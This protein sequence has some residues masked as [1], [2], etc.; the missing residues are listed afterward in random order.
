MRICFVGGGTGGHFYPLIAVAEV[1]KD[2]QPDAE[3]YY[4]GP[5]PFDK[6]SLAA[7]NITYVYCPAGK[8]RRYFSIQNFFDLFRSFFG[9]FA[10]VWKLYLIYPDVIFS[11][12]SY[13]AVP[14]LLAARFLRIPV[15][16]HESDAKPGRANKLAKKFAKYIAISHDEVSSYFPA[17]KTAL[18]GIPLRREIR[19]ITPNAFAVLGIPSD[20]PLVYVTGGSLG[21]ERINNIIIRTL[22]DLLP[23]Y[24]VF[25]QVGEANL[26]ESKLAA[27]TLLQDSPLQNNYYIVGS[28]PAGTVALLL[29]AAAIVIT[30]A[31]STSLFEI[32]EH[33]KPSIIIPI[34]EEVSHDQRSN[35]FSYARN[36]AGVVIEE[37][38]LTPHLLTEEIH[39]IIGN[40]P[41]YAS[42][43]QA[44]KATAIP[45]A[46]EKIAAILIQIGKEH[47]S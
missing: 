33:G 8:L 13:T 32:A 31:G 20:K 17:E 9:M 34:P 35:A 22:S 23:H 3:L 4:I 19:T 27:Q 7:M 16:I 14:I 47:G 38:N 46:A 45:G 1:L 41:R 24:R 15:V 6:N 28:V 26:E 39:S 25:H 40:P 30:R 21:A 18:T 42:M 11:K 36:G 12:G 44:A 5:A 37:H 43:A 29:D 10:A 2:T